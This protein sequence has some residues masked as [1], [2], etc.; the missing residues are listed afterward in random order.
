MI[1]A[2]RWDEAWTPAQILRD[3]PTGREYAAALE[4]PSRAPILVDA[5]DQVLSFPPIINSAGLGRV[6]VGMSE[7]F[8]EVTGDGLDQVL[9]AANILAANL[10]DRGAQIQPV[11]TQYPFDTPRGREVQS[12]H[13]LADRRTVTVPVAEFGRLLGLDLEIDR[14]TS[15]LHAFGLSVKQVSILKLGSGD[16]DKPGLRVTAPAFR[17]DYLHAVDAIED[18]AI[19][20]GYD[21]FEP[22]LPESFTVGGLA[23]DTAFADLARD[24]AIGCGFDEGIGNL[25]T[26]VEKLR[27]QMCVSEEAEL[28]PCMAGRWCASRTS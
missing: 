7:L 2:A 23:P 21:V 16:G 28:G 3:H 1:P 6:T 19:S 12:P 9:L 20:Y 18:C 15:S 14:I 17:A 10:H 5:Q 11:L 27:E 26:S 25:L 22:L 24:L 4:D 13:P 8:V